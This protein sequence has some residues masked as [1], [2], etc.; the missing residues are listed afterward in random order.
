[1]IVLL[2]IDILH[3]SPLAVTPKKREDS[4]PSVTSPMTVQFGAMNSASSNFGNFVFDIGIQRVEGTT[5][6]Y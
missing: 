4:L 5:N 3:V 2:P 1:M 6:F